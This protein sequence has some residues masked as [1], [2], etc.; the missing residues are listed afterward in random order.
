M[1]MQPPH[2]GMAPAICRLKANVINL[3]IIYL[4]KQ[5]PLSADTPSLPLP[6]SIFYGKVQPFRKVMR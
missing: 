1:G 3:R 2:H 5:I 4:K 6:F